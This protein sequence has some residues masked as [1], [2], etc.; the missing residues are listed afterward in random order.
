LQVNSERQSLLLDRV[1]PLVRPGGRL[2]YSVCTLTREET[3]L[4]TERF[5]SN[6][7]EF[8]REDLRELMPSSWRELFD[9]QGALRTLPHRHHGMDA[10]YAVSFRRRD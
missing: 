7:A 5:L 8:Q 1:A 2:L 9:E 3:T 6:H 4:V 10:F